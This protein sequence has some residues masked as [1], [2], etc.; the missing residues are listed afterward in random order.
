MV[1]KNLIFFFQA[2]LAFGLSRDK[3]KIVKPSNLKDLQLLTA[4]NA[5]RFVAP[6][7]VQELTKEEFEQF[8]VSKK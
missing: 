2:G 6:A 8:N 1:A 4:K 5:H 3:P 7:G